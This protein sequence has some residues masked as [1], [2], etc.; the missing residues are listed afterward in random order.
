MN[1][2]RC[3]WYGLSVGAAF[4]GSSWGQT[5]VAD[6]G[7]DWL[8]YAEGLRGQ[9]L[10]PVA[11]YEADPNQPG[12]GYFYAYWSTILGKI[13]RQRAAAGVPP[14]SEDAAL[15]RAGFLIIEQI[16]RQDWLGPSF[17]NGQDL[18]AFLQKAG[19]QGDP[20][21]VKAYIHLAID[22]AFPS[23]K[24][25]DLYHSGM[26]PLL[27]MR[28]A[29]S[30]LYRSFGYAT[31]NVDPVNGNGF[32]SHGI[33]PYEL[34]DAGRIRASTYEVVLV[35]METPPTPS[36]LIADWRLNANRHFFT[37]YDHI[38]PIAINVRQGARIHGGMVADSRQLGDRPRIKG[39][40][41]TGIKLNPVTG[42]FVGKAR[43]KGVYRFTITATYRLYRGEG[44]SGLFST[45]GVIRVTRER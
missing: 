28:G 27:S 45:A 26:R 44:C 18:P 43:K 17:P 15:G 8:G 16:L 12:R 1:W 3:L 4:L 23:V 5:F 24:T 9:T 11:A 34:T 6:K 42:Q 31:I 39:R 30:P 7:G 40:L 14:L 38:I 25:E 13:N 41:P 36:R 2:N 29:L 22:S 37:K 32:V 10:V 20:R 35:S 21:K 19:Y 33:D